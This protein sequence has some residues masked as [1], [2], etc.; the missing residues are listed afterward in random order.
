MN[1]ETLADL[2]AQLAMIGAERVA[3]QFASPHE[4]WAPILIVSDGR[5][6]ETI[7]I[8]PALFGSI[9]AKDQAAQV[10]AAEIR[11]HAA[12]GCA[13]VLSAWS[14][15]DTGDYETAPPERGDRVEVLTVM[16]LDRTQQRIWSAPI[17]R[18]DDTPP[19]LGP[20]QQERSA[21]GRFVEPLRRALTLQG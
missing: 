19:R 21:E 6:S 8:D 7:A 10:M 11:G 3:E 15:P 18:S 4:D 17:Q 2:C 12:A 20:W 5:T 13:L 1:D 9:E 14:V 16:A